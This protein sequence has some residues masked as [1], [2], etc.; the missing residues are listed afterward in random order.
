MH[1]GGGVYHEVQTEKLGNFEETGNREPSRIC[2]RDMVWCPYQWV[3]ITLK[4][5]TYQVPLDPDPHKNENKSL[6]E[7]AIK[8]SPNTW[9]IPRA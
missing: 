8:L 2:R 7:R 4:S 1:K 5:E 3:H 9:S 6:V